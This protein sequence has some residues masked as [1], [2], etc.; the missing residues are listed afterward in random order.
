MF[1]GDTAPKLAGVRILFPWGPSL[2]WGWGL[3]KVFPQS[4]QLE[5]G[6]KDWGVG[7][8]NLVTEIL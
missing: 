8:E 3:V 1:T 7:G 5:Q 4:G 6:G 2:Q